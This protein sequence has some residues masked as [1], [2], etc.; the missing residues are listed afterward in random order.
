MSDEEAQFD[1]S[2]LGRVLGR[3]RTRQ[4]K[5]EGALIVEELLGAAPDLGQCSCS[6]GSAGAPKA[7]SELELVAS[8]GHDAA[9]RA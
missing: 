9:R 7:D 1:G 4:R 6:R 8:S 3:I 2:R 5:G